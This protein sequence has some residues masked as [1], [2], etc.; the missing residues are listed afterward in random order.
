MNELASSMTGGPLFLCLNLCCLSEHIHSGLAAL[1]NTRKEMQDELRQLVSDLEATERLAAKK[2]LCRKTWGY[3]V[4]VF[5]LL[6]I[7]LKATTHASSFLHP[8]GPLQ[9]A[10]LIGV[11]VLFDATSKLFQSTKDGEYPSYSG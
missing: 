11:S 8:L 5:E 1:T 10:A 9:S 7:D 6:S 4:K 2:A 3:V